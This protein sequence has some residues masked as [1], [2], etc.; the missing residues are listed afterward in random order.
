MSCFSCSL[1]LGIRQYQEN[2]VSFLGLR[3]SS[4]SRLALPVGWLSLHDG[5]EAAISL[6]ISNPT[7]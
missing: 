6:K 7:K 3:V 2:L 1:M 4:S 5:K